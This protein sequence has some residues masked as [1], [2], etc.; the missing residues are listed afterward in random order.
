[1]KPEAREEKEVGKRAGSRSDRD[2]VETGAV[3][4]CLPQLG[5]RGKLRRKGS[6]LY[7]REGDRKPNIAIAQDE[8]LKAFRKHL[9]GRTTRRRSQGK[10]N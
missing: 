7:L 9:K 1:M 6:P 10:G 3:L 4:C 8:L 5:K 2:S